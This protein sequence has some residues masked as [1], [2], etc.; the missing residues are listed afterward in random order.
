MTTRAEVRQA[1]A[2]LLTSELV[3]TGK[4][5]EAVYSYQVGDFG[6]LSPVVAVLSAGTQRTQLTR[7]GS[8]SSYWLDVYVFALY[9]LEDGTLTES[10]AEDRLDAI[11][12]VISAAV[13][14]HQVTAQWGKIEYEGRT[15][16]DGIVIGGLGYRRELIPLKFYGT[17]N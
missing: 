9:A 13:D 17:G 1:F 6:T 16:T 8:I 15:V 3:G 4:L 12:K 2:A 11:E 7:L 10:D 14:T 5:A